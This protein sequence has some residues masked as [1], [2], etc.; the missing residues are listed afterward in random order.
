MSARNCVYYF[1]RFLSA[2]IINSVSNEKKSSQCA[3]NLAKSFIITF[4]WP[5]LFNPLYPPLLPE[6]KN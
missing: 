2:R 3:Q 5:L 1:Y 4:N 6:L